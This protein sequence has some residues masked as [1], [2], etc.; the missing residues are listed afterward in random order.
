MPLLLIDLSRQKVKGEQTRTER[1]GVSSRSHNGWEVSDLYATETFCR[2]IRSG[3]CGLEPRPFRASTYEV[4][5]NYAMQ[6]KLE[7]IDAYGEPTD[8]K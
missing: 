4:T 2:K 3:A 1:L 8:L 6:T 5:L 7:G